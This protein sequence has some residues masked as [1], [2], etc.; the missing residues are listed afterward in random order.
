M[1]HPPQH[2]DVGLR[3][4]AEHGHGEPALGVLA[5]PAGVDLRLRQPLHHGEGLE[6]RCRVEVGLAQVPDA[7]GV[8]TGRRHQSHREA[9][10]GEVHGDRRGGGHRGLQGGGDALAAVGAAPV[11]EEDRGP[12]LPGLLLPPDHQLADPG[13]AAPVHPAQVVAA[14]VVADGDVLGRADREGPRAV[15]AGAGPAAAERDRGQRDRA[16]RD[17][18]RDGAAE[19]PAQLDQ[20]ERIAHAHRH[21]PHLE[22]AADVGAHLVGDVAPPPVPDAV[23][24]EARPGAEDVGKVVLQQ[25]HP[26]RRPALVGEGQVD[27]GGLA[28]G[29]ELRRDRADQG[30]PV[31]AAPHERGGHQGEGEHQD[32]DAGERGLAH[33]HRAEH[34]GHPGSEERPPAGGQTG[35]ALTHDARRWAGAPP[36]PAP[37]R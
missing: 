4:G 3:D 27:A 8:L 32:A 12:R 5:E 9:P 17:G 18:E 1:L 2:G 7:G 24:H 23:E 28:G 15:V 16:W 11:V 34:G 6:Q 10:G 20:A 21:R 35:K 31:A 29:H 14:A 33:E 19:A 37:R 22:P 36:A 30:E 26:A 25:Q 13:G